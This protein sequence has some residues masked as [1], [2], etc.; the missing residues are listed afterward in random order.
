MPVVDGFCHEDF[1]EVKK[2][3]ASNFESGEE[4][5]AQLCVY[6]GSELVVDLWGSLDDSNAAGYG[7]DSLQVI[8]VKCG[9]NF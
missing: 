9:G 6:I 1:L 5:S 2:L 8:L 3:F 7:P 4:E